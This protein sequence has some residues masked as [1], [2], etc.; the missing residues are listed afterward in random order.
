[1]VVGPLRNSSAPVGSPISL[2]F[3]KQAVNSAES[4]CIGLPIEAAVARAAPMDIKGTDSTSG[5]KARQQ[6]SSTSRVA[7]AS[8]PWT[9]DFRLADSS[10]WWAAETLRVHRVPSEVRLTRRRSGATVG[11]VA[12]ETTQCPEIG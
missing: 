6:R 8:G 9:K 5:W 4:T 11:C 2:T 10:R 1:V 3:S 7:S 12:S